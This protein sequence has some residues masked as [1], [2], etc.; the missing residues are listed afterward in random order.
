M[1]TFRGSKTDQYNGGCKRYVGMTGN[2]R[3]AVLAF[4]EWRSMQ[5][6]HFDAAGS[7]GSPMFTIPN[8]HVLGRVEVHTYY[9]REAAAALGL[10]RAVPES[11]KRL[12]CS[13]CCGARA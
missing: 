10:P 1:D 8:G 2:F 5:L 11:P 7:C 9:R 4:R 13:R 12:R 3:C 6:E